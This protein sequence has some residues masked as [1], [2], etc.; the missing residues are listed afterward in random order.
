MQGQL[1]QLLEQLRSVKTEL[2]MERAR[3]DRRRA[4]MIAF[5]QRVR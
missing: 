3:S 2:E 1:P 5:K 4:H